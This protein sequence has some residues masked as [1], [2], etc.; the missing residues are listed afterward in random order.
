MLDREQIPAY[1]EAAGV[2]SWHL[3]GGH[4]YVLLDEL[5]ELAKDGPAMWGC[6]GHQ[7]EDRRPASL[8]LKAHITRS[9]LQAKKSLKHMNKGLGHHTRS[10]SRVGRGPGFMTS[11][12]TARRQYGA[13]HLRW[14]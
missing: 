13:T 10:D 12:R 14:S 3:Y 2:R 6:G 1:L 9:G 4:G 5:F 7:D 11:P 8:G